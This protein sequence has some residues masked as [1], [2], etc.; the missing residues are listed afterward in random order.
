MDAS[1]FRR[2]GAWLPRA[3]GQAWP[4]LATQAFALAVALAP[5]WY[6]NL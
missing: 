2:P 3:R 6:L 1:L 4:V 5:V